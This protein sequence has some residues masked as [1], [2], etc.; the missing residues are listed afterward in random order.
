M[1]YT[2][3]TDSC[4]DLPIEYLESNYVKYINLTYR[5]EENEFYDNFGQDLDYKSFYNFMRQGKIP[6]TSQVN[7]QAYY[8]MFKQI[9]DEG[10]D[11]LYICVSSGLSGTYNSANIAKDMIMDEEKYRNRK[12]QIVDVLT[13]SLG[14][15]LMV[16][17]AVNM[18]C[19]GFTLE[20]ISKALEE[21][22]FN[23]NTYMTVDDLDYLKKGGRISNAAAFVGKLLNIKPLLTLD[24][25]GKVIPILKIKGKKALL[26]KLAEIISK[27]MK[28][29]SEEIVCISHGDSIEEAEKLKDI[30]LKNTE[31]KEVIISN[32]GPAVGTYGGPG[33]LAIF[34]IGEHR[35]NHIIDI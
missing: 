15:G 17:K 5:L 34:F 20:K 23:L 4:C 21:M 10:N 26:K 32:I 31:V 16:I 35:Q 29:T 8:E 30:I 12:I 33:A 22:K 3:L 25:E 13:A 9:L 28:N 14:Q 27:K 1:K 18:K 7:P 24:N 2:I 11:I 19:N 6:K